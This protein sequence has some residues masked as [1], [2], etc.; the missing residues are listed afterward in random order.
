[1]RDSFYGSAGQ[2][3]SGIGP[4][5]WHCHC[6]IEVGDELL[7]FDAQGVLGSEVSTA[8]E[9]AREDGEPDLDL[10]EP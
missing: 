1:V 5:E 10:V 4:A 3:F 9:F 6:C 2:R 8:K 7:D